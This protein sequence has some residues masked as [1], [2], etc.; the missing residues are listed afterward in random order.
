MALLGYHL[1]AKVW[2][3]SDEG[4]VLTPTRVALLRQVMKYPSLAEAARALQIPYKKAHRL[5][6]SLDERLGGGVVSGA[7]GGAAGGTTTLSGEGSR[8]LDDYERLCNRVFETLATATIL[9]R[10]ASATVEGLLHPGAQAAGANVALPDASAM[11]PL[12]DR[13]R[14]VSGHNCPGMVLGVR[15]AAAGMADLGVHPLKPVG[16][17]SVTVETARCAADAIQAVSD[18]SLGRASLRVVELGKMAAT[19]TRGEDQVGV[20]VVAL[21]TS[22]EAAD[23]LFPEIRG[24]KQR[25]MVAYRLLPDEALLRKGRVHLLDR[26]ATARREVHK[27]ALCARCSEAFEPRFGSFDRGELICA[28]CAGRSYFGPVPPSPAGA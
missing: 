12:Y 24:R 4:P 22:R 16:P 21:E 18:T 15:M 20:R 2:V 6:A 1:R 5:V 25:Q 3:E 26:P 8:L 10:P 17:V 11:Q 28:G 19:F 9:G 7:S 23:R 13:A 27:R 14:L